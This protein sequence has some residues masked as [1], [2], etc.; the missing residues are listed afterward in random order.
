LLALA[1]HVA[2][3]QGL[4][5]PNFGEV[6]PQ[7]IRGFKVPTRVMDYDQIFDDAAQNVLGIWST[8]AAA[9]WQGD[10]SF[11][12]VIGD[13][14]LDTGMDRAGNLVFWGK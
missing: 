9:V 1:R 7:Y 5:Y 6:D 14:N 8:L 12:K 3:G 2:A 11:R 10:E 13:W 4:T